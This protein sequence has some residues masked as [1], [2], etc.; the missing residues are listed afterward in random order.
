[1]S[2][3]FWFFLCEVQICFV[4]SL[5]TLPL[6]WLQNTLPDEEKLAGAALNLKQVGDTSVPVILNIIGNDEMRQ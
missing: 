5:N 2:A 1:M 6:L 3:H 4:F